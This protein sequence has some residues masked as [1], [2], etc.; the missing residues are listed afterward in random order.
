MQNIQEFKKSISYRTEVRTF[1]LSRKWFV[2]RLPIES[3]EFSFTLCDHILNPLFLGGKI[4]E[5]SKLSFF[6]ER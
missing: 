1:F 5:L 2:L 6:W 3:R 4:I